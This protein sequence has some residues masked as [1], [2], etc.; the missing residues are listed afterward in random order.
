MTW[1]GTVGVGQRSRTASLE[2]E[3]VLTLVTLPALPAAG[4]PGR[5][6]AAAGLRWMRSGECRERASCLR[7]TGGVLQKQ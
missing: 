5:D 3:E 4:V 6:L 2:E 7:I 1:T